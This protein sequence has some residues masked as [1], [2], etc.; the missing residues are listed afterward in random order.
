LSQS[1]YICYNNKTNKFYN[2]RHVQ[3]IENIF[4]YSHK[5]SNEHTSLTHL[6]SNN[7]NPNYSSP[8]TVTH[9]IKPLPTLN[10]NLTPQTTYSPQQT[11]HS[12]PSPMPHSQ[13][14]SPLTPPTQ[15][16]NHELITTL[17]NNQPIISQTTPHSPTNLPPNNSPTTSV[18]QPSHAP[19]VIEPPIKNK[20]KLIVT[21]HPMQTRAKC[22]IFKPKQ[23][24]LATKYPLPNPIEPTCV[25][26][27]M[28]STKWQQAM[29]DEFMALMRNGT[30]TLVPPSPHYNVIG[31]KWV[32]R[33]KRNP[34]GSISRYKARLVAKGF[35]QRP[36]IDYKDTF[37][38]VIKPQTIKLVLCIALSKG[39]S[40]TQMDVNNAFLHGTISED[41]YMTQ[42]T[43]FIHSSFPDYVC[44]LKKALYGLKQAPRAWFNALK[45]FLLQFGFVNAKSDTSLFIYN[46]GSTTAYFLVYVDDLLLCGNNSSFL[47]QFKQAL[48]EQFSLK[49]LGPP[50]HFL[51]VEIIPTKTGLFLTQHHYIRD[52]LLRANMGDCKP[53]S[54]PMATS[55]C[56]QPKPDSTSCDSKEFRSILGALHYL[57]I[58]RPDIAF[59]VNKLAQRMQAPTVT[60]MQALKRILRYL[61]STISNGLHLT[62]SS[63]SNLTSFCDADWAG[64]TT[65][66]KSTGAYLIYFGPNIISWSCKKQPTVAKSSTEA[67]YRTIATTTQELIWIQNLLQELHIPIT[68][69]TIFSDNIGATYLCANPVFHSRMKHVA[70]DYHFVRDLV[71]TKK[72]QVSHVP[73]SH[74][75]ADL[76]TKSLSSTR[77]H[78]LKDKIGVIEDTSILRGRVGILTNIN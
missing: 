74:Q 25:S 45:T 31:N 1:A 29:T 39:W 46:S 13:P 59:S 35:H 72:L 36:G 3:F 57:S 70:I 76:L 60:D 7:I 68:A 16:D 2:S 23:L 33:L 62:R 42:P 66:R 55:F 5:S 38:P 71:A 51:G 77:H 30:W 75:L 24:N 73:T 32:F 10:P 41:V 43:G 22:G 37:S 48:A 61:K 8:L 47:D 49:D 28:K 78:F 19:I 44:K 12:N 40:L 63:N 65:D 58:T 11:N 17:D 50:S 69:P 18:S 14:T 6:N 15:L 54:T 53:V 27:A 64:D 67:E 20:S 34:D 4:P 9:P 52:I 26:Q 21:D 56:S